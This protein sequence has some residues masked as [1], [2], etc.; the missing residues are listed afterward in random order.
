MNLVTPK[1][2]ESPSEEE[3]L[4]TNPL[5]K[6]ETSQPLFVQELE[7]HGWWVQPLCPPST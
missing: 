6:A 5:A 4:F 2:R 3:M 1:E 7:A